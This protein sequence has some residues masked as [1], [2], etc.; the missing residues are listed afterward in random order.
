MSTPS[1]RTCPETF[2]PGTRSCILLRH[3]ISVD[4]PQPDG[5]IMA[6]TMLGL[7]ERST[8]N[9]ACFWLYQAFSFLTWILGFAAA[10]RGASAYAPTSSTLFIS[11]LS[12]SSPTPGRNPHPDVDNHD[13][14]Y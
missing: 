4:F 3:L 8:S 1:K 13:G 14:H 11:P 5:P 6:V 2:D 9:R 7:T 10:V 12:V